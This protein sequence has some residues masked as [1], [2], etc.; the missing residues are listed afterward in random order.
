MKQ[1][2]VAIL[3]N[4]ALD[5]ILLLHRNKDPYANRLNGIGGKIERG[6]TVQEAFQREMYEETGLSPNELAYYQEMVTMTFP[7]G[8]KL[9]CFYGV[10][11]YES[12]ISVENEEG[13][14][15]WYS[16][17][18]R[19]LLNA[20]NSMLAG[21][22]NLPYLIQFARNLEMSRKNKDQLFQKS[23]IQGK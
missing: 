6:E 23:I 10:L 13:F 7:N 18:E 2:V 5:K 19:D 12:I 21:D 16:I 17:E 8:L 20:S 3:L 9:V 4:P 11:S 14:L 22:G 1:Y 15:T